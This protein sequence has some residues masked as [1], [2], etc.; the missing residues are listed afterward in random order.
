MI[1]KW[2]AVILTDCLMAMERETDHKG[3]NSHLRQKNPGDDFETGTLTEA[4][5]VFSSRQRNDKIKIH[6]FV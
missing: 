6:I 4:E 5:S 3:G 2:A 1:S